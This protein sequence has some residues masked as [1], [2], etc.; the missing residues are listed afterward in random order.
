MWGGEYMSQR[1]YIALLMPYMATINNLDS[2][3]VKTSDMTMKITYTLT[4]A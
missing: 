3:V 4:E 2:A 1:R